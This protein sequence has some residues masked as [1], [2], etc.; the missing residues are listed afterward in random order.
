LGHLDGPGGIHLVLIDG[1][2]AELEG[3]ELA[4]LI[5]HRFEGTPPPIVLAEAH[6]D[7]ELVLGSREAGVSHILV[8][9][10]E[11]DAELARLLESQLGL[12]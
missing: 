7:A 9:P 3:L 5:H 11:A 6:V 10:Y 8:K 2:V 12:S 4:S 1:G